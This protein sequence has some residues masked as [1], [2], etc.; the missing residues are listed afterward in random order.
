MEPD[1]AAIWAETVVRTWPDAFSLVSLP[2]ASLPDAA[3]LVAESRDRFAALVVEADEVSLTVA[4][5]VWT[6]ARHRIAFRCEAGPF[7][8]ITLGIDVDLGVCGYLLPAA[9][10][11]ADAGISIVPQCAYLKDHLLVH[12][13]DA[14]RAVAL[15]ESLVDDARRVV[16][17]EQ[18]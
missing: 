18:P 1:V 13:S 4:E 16:H 3:A 6:A 11:L 15:L 14:G 2:H 7:A 8:A 17:G 10:R 5:S 12:A 9:R